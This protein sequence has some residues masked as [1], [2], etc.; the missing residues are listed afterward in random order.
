MSTH[1]NGMPVLP[2]EAY[3]SQEWFDREQAQ[4][5]SKTWSLAGFREDITEPGQY[6]SVQAGLNNIF[7]VMGRDHRLRAFHNICRHRGTQ[8]LRAEGKTQKAITCPYHDWTYDLEGNLISVPEQEKEFP[9]IDLS[10]NGL[11][12]ASVDIWRGMLWVHP[13]ENAPSIINWFGEVEPYLAPYDPAGLIETEE[14]YSKHEIK[15]NWKIIVENYI[16]GY[17]LAH[18]HSHTLNMYDHS[19]IECEFI[20]PHFAFWEPLADFYAAEVEKVTPMPLIPGIPKDKMGAWVPMLF[21]GIGL[22]ESENSW[23]TFHITP[24]APDRSMVEIRT[25]VANESTWAFTKAAMASASFWDKHL[26]AK[27]NED[28][29]VDPM[30]SGDFMQEDIYACEQQQKSLQSPYFEH[31]PSS[32]HGEK[33]VRDHQRVVAEWV[34]RKP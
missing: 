18:L 21:P 23:S 22:G 15:A 31:G 20:G 34:E 29:K 3:T 12:K 9:D 13:D 32:K 14:G 16:D 19:K 5:F 33:P 8:L 24:I 26:G 25:R 28:P 1:S 30:S 11:K 10:C 7:I 27:Y 2:K 17:H 4:I 6:I